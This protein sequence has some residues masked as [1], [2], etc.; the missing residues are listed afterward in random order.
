M[1]K[2]RKHQYEKLNQSQRQQQ[3][4]G[5]HV[6]PVTAKLSKL[7]RLLSCFH[8]VTNLPPLPSLFICYN[9]LVFNLSILGQ[10]LTVK[11]PG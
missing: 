4:E 10:A 9:Y 5:V 7:S 3:D 11:I 2:P 8:S 6:V 1:F